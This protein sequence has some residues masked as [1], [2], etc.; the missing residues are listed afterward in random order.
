MSESLPKIARL[1]PYPLRVEKDRVYSWC[2]CGLSQK[3]PLCDG[4]HKGTDYKSLKFQCEEEKTV[5]MCGCKHTKTPPY[6]DGSHS[7]IKTSS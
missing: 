6:C 3:Q 4:A 7:R 1:G 2:R 5:W